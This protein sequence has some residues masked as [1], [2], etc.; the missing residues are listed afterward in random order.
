MNILVTGA[1]G[2]IGSN[3]IRTLV[4]QTSHTPAILRRASSTF[5]FDKEIENRCEFYE[6]DEDADNIY[7]IVKEAK[8]DVVIHLASLTQS[9]ERKTQIDSFLIVVFELTF[10]FVLIVD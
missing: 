7:Q 9:E 10:C 4:R 1:T 5:Q 8:P 2:F 3:L 6:L